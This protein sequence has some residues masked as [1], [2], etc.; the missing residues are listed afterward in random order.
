MKK[1]IMKVVCIIIMCVTIVSIYIYTRYQ[2]TSSERPLD[3]YEGQ[4]DAIYS[5]S[6]MDKDGI[7]DQTDILEGALNYVNTKPKYASKYYDT[8]Y[9]DDNYGVCTDVVA[10]ALM[11]AG[12][13]LQAEVNT[14]ILDNPK[15]YG[16][17]K[18]DEN[19]DFRRVKN[20]KIY[21]SN[22]AIT[23]TKDIYDIDE[24]QGGD[25]V[26]FEK[27]I[28][29]VSDRRNRDG[30]TYV[31]HHSSPYQKYYEEDILEKRDDIVGHYRIM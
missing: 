2:N 30:V 5:S 28:G 11:N 14:D 17:E 26:V 16:I 21:L 10:F 4:I 3:E 23:L 6:D 25:I 1:L 22:K 24:W 12:Y 13:D 8:G 7:D 27:H 9:P 31:I 29:I 15:E 18:A 20:L 19:I